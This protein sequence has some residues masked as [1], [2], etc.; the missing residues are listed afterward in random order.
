MTGKEPVWYATA[1]ATG[2]L[3]TA[4][5]LAHIRQPIAED[6]LN[7]LIAAETLYTTGTAIHFEL[8]ER[9]NTYSPELYLQLL[10]GVFRLLG[11]SVPVARL[12]GIVSG[13]LSLALV[14]FITRTLAY[15][16]LSVRLQWA[17]TVCLLY[18]VTPGFIQSV[19]ILAIDNT[20]LVPSVLLLCW[21]FV[22]Y[23]NEQRTGWAVLTGLA[24][25]IALW[26]RVTTPPVI[27]CVMSVCA[28]ASRHN[29]KTKVIAVGA[30]LAGALVFLLSWYWYCQAQRVPFDG[31]FLYAFGS[32]S[33]KAE[34]WA[35][36]PIMQNLLYVVLWIGVF[37]ML[38][39][40][41]AL[42][43][44]MEA[45][46]AERCVADSDVF[47]LCGLSLFLGY[48][49]IGG[50]IFGYPKYHAPAI[51]LLYIF[52]GITL[53]RHL[54]ASGY[55]LEGKEGLALLVAGIACLLQMLI[56]GDGLYLIRQQ[57]REA[58]TFTPLS[59]LEVL[60]GIIGKTVMFAA[61]TALLWVV[62]ARMSF[63]TVAGLLLALSVGCNLGLSLLHSWADYQTG[64]NHGGRGTVETAEYIRARIPVDGRIIVPHE[65]NYY[66]QLPESPYWH[67]DIWSN[68]TKLKEQ[69]AERNTW[70]LVYSL[71]TNT[72]QQVQ[73]ILGDRSL[74]EW[75]GQRY[76]HALVGTYHI[77]IRKD[78]KPSSGFYR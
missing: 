73:A 3:F 7:Y 68:T 47:L 53:S 29:S 72:I 57:L 77:W 15:G 32:I 46:I 11:V 36:L 64:F 10:V 37:S 52:A 39:I 59:Y 2:L 54:R 21:S 49:F 34:K 67:G 13:L 23:L 43:M 25:T 8:H 70:G 55:P 42:S 63:R 58:L 66:L 56:L 50:V 69:L 48:L 28:L 6:D 22:E 45:F 76:D 12:P 78:A 24:M 60:R 61:A 20:I 41:Y 62:A 18:A 4:L 31:P 27:A 16:S 65:V 26:G 74:Q 38:L 35:L 1:I 17:A 44:R 51:P 19:H 71:T 75:L 30:L 40:L 5:S 9:I 33:G 14:F